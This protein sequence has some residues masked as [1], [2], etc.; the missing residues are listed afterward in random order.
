[1]IIFYQIDKATGK[2]FVPLAFKYGKPYTLLP[3]E[4]PVILKLGSALKK[5]F[6]V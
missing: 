3:T 4:L 5:F 2:L 6:D 1:M